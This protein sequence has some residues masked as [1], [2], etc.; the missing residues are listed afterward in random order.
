LAL[1]IAATL[2]YATTAGDA[3]QTG[4]VNRLNLGVVAVEAKVGGE[5]VHG[6]GTVIDAQRGLVLTSA[7][8]VW[9]ATSLK[10]GTGVGIL[11]GRIVARAPCDELALVETQPRVPG[12]ISLA[13]NAAPAPAP[14]A[15]VTAYGRRLTR[16]ASGILTLPATVT[17]SPLKLDALLVP[18]AAGG[19]VLDAKGRL[20]G[21][22]TP[23]GGTMPWEAVKSRLDELT[24]GPRRVFV[25]WRGQYDCA[26]RLNRVT[27]TEHPAF[28][29]RDARLVVPIPAT[30]IPGS[31]VDE[32]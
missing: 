14:G 4:S 12:L 23:T 24:P 2:G 18:E 29:P 10:L 17:R 13:D 25:G 3:Q 11:H 15:V 21:I 28:K 7:R 27:R 8:A 22:G 9:G 20:V 26:A 6:S 1:L 32:G 16:P 5:P 31:E 30:R 19:P